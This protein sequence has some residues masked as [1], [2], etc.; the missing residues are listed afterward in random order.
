MKEYQISTKE[1][2]A[3]VQ[4]I[5]LEHIAKG[6]YTWAV[7]IVSNKTSK[8]LGFYRFKEQPNISS[9]AGLMRDCHANS[10]KAH[11]LEETSNQLTELPNGV[12]NDCVSS[13]LV[14]ESSSLNPADYDAIVL[15][16]GTANADALRFNTEAQAFVKAFA[17]AGKPIAAIC[18]APWVL[19]DSG[20]AKD[21]TLTG[22]KTIA[23]DL[24]NAG[25]TFEDKSVVVDGNFI[26]SRQPEDIPDFVTAIEA[27]LHK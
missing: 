14:C 24:K 25:A 26:T 8:I 5:L 22:Y 1:K 2:K 4:P 6:V 3:L 17:V 15:P 11:A 20:L 10:D 9:F 12:P 19:V 7:T 18:H 27:A 16:G 23:I 13:S 21:K